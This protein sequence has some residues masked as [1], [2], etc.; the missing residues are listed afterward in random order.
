MGVI[1][2]L[3]GTWLPAGAAELFFSRN[4]PGSAPP[5]FDITLSSDGAAS[6]REAPDEDPLEFRVEAST[7]ATLM[8]RVQALDALAKPIASKRK[9]AFTGDKTLRFKGDDGRQA[10]VK[11]SYTEDVEAQDIVSWFL[12][13]GETARHR[14]DLERV[15]RFDRLGVNDALLRLQT[16]FDRDRVVAPDQLVPVLQEIV[17]QDRILHLA[18]SRAAAMLEKIQAGRGGEPPA[19]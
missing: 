4:F 12:R 14:I 13:A 2:L 8:R 7:V 3:A 6:Y 17:G 15:L 11:F 1:A 16:S 19:P 9:V 5:Y 18:R 10:E